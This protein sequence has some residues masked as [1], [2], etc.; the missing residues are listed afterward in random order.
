MCANTHRGGPQ[1]TRSPA[2][3]AFQVTVVHPADTPERSSYATHLSR[4][5]EVR[6]EI[7]HLRG[8]WKFAAHVRQMK[9]RARFSRVPSVP[10][11]SPGRMPRETN[12]GSLKQ[13]MKLLGRLRDQA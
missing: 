3:L 12:S 5:R 8:L 7:W 4:R 10:V 9:R 11:R 6:S 2:C 1:N 13:K